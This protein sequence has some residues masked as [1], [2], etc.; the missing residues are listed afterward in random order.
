MSMTYRQIQDAVLD[1]GFDEGDRASAQNWIQ[2]RHAWLWDLKPWTFRQA[3]PVTVTFTSGSQTVNLG[4]VTDMHAVIVLY[5]ANG[6]PI[7]GVADY[8]Q[9]FDRYNAN[10]SLTTGAPEAYTVVNGTILVGPQG[11]G[12][13]GLLMYEKSKPALSADGDSTGLPD[14]YDLALV[15]GAKAEGFKLKVV[16]E[17]A[18]SFDQDFTAALNAL[19]ANYLTQVREQGQQWGAYRPGR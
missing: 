10:A 9:F 14:G 2:F 4:T 8:R 1:S 15:H 11:D 3:G 19:S 7:R 17:L 13:T 6:S 12:S 5:D 16:P 18:A